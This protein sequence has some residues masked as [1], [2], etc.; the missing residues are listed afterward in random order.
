MPLLP[1]QRVRTVRQYGMHPQAASVRFEKMRLP[2]LL[3]L[4]V[5]EAG[6]LFSSASLPSTAHRLRS[7]IL[8]RIDALEKVGLGYLRLTVLRPPYRAASPRE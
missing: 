5:E 7:E 6:G 8:K 1:G 2:E 3:N 4:S